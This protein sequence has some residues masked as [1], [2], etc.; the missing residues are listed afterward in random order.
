[1]LNL[2]SYITIGEAPN[3]IFLDFVNQVDIETSFENMT[4][5]AK[6]VIPRKL[7]FKGKPLAVGNEALFKRGEKIKIELGYDAN[8]K[9]VFQG[10]ISRVHLSLPIVLE[11]E[12]ETYTLKKNILVNKTYESVSLTTLLKYIMPS[13]V[14]YTT[15]GFTFENLGKIRITNRATTAMVLDMLRKS[16]N[17]YT[18]YRDGVFYIGL[19][20]Q[21]S[22]QKQKTFDFEKNI[23]DD[24]NLEWEQKDD[25][26]IKVYGVSVQSDNTKFEYW[27]PSKDTPGEQIK[28]SV[29]GISEADLK[30]AVIRHYDSF[31]FDGYKGSFL[32]FGEPLVNHGDVVKFNSEKLTERNEGVYL[33]KSV[34]RSFGM[35]GYRQTITPQKR[36]TT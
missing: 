31:Q 18:F 23:I 6:I 12:D 11:C 17:I 15:N 36:L 9:T 2:S 16:Y 7:S 1:M 27:Y 25:V 14:E 35:Q 30:K 26:P 19:P 29:A 24:K 28:Y 4:D 34:T 32:T 33:I 22:L 21:T 3:Q 8:L 13:T 5:T 20:F 10:Y